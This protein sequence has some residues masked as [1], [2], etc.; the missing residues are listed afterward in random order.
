MSAWCRTSPRDG[1]PV[2]LS[3][4]GAELEAVIDRFAAGVVYV[5]LA[6]PKMQ[7]AASRLPRRQKGA[8][9]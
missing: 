9:G 6:K 3:M 2:R 1:D 8:A 5:R 4:G 7:K